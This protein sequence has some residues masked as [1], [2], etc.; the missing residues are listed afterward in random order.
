M[1]R[2]NYA[3]PNYQLFVGAFNVTAYV[4]SISLSVQPSE[5]STPL[6]WSGDFQ[7]SYNRK[8]LLNSLAE[9]AFD[10]IAEPNRWRP[11]QVPVSLVINGHQFPKLRID[12]YT[13]DPQLRQGRGTLIQILALADIDRPAIDPEIEAGAATPLVDV[14]DRLLLEAYSGASIAPPARSITGITGTLDSKLSTRNPIAD[15]Q[16]LCATSWQWLAVNS[17]EQIITVS[18]DPSDR[19]LLFSRGLGQVEWSPD[20]DAI[21][22]AAE[23]VIVTGSHQVIDRSSDCRDA[24]PNPNLD[25]Q[26]REREFITKTEQPRNLL[27]SHVQ[28]AKNDTNLVVAERKTVR[29]GYG[30]LS[31][32][33]IIGP[34]AT[35]IPLLVGNQLATA[36]DVPGSFDL[37]PEDGTEVLQTLTVKEQPAGV[38]FNDLGADT[39]LIVA[40]LTVETDVIK[41]TWK[42]RGVINPATKLIRTYL[43]IEKL[44]RLTTQRIP[45]DSNHSGEIDPKTGK[46]RCLEKPPAAEPR[47]PAAEIRLKT[48]VLRGECKVRPAGWTP[49]LKRPLIEDFGFLPSQAHADRLACQIAFRE[50]RRRDTV[51]I[52]MPLPSEWIAAGF[53]HLFR[54]HIHNAEFHADGPIISI[55]DGKAEFSFAGARIGTIPPVVDPP[56]PAPFI[57]GASLQLLL[58]SQ[59]AIGAAGVPFQSEQFIARGQTLV[60]TALSPLP[61]GLVLSSQGI[62]SGTP[63]APFSGVVSIQVTDG[64][65]IVTGTRQINI[66]P[67]PSPIPSVIQVI[68]IE[69]L[70]RPSLASLGQSIEVIQMISKP[71]GAIVPANAPIALVDLSTPF[72]VPA[73]EVV[74]DL[75]TPFIK[76]YSIGGFSPTIA[77]P[78]GTSGLSQIV[79]FAADDAFQSIPDIGFDITIYGGN[80]RSTLFVGSNSYLTMTAGSSAYNSISDTNPGMG[81]FVGGA[82]RSWRSVWVGSDQPGSFRIRWEGSGSSSTSGPADSL[83]EITL[84]DNG[85]IMLV[86]GAMAFTGGYNSLTDGLGGNTTAYTLTADSSW[87]F[88]PQGAGFTVQQGSYN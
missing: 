9:S 13:Y 14:I 56:L 76:R 44:E 72:I 70:S 3:T 40:E 45:L 65:S 12:R 6:L 62:L 5:P 69:E 84:F 75:S 52:K 19:P 24:T 39:S 54:C 15:A 66:G 79:S 2:I 41:A 55:A 68:E 80:R 47:Q 83:W 78:L 4:D 34:W 49:L 38:V 74:S 50:A 43:E 82:D 37:P 58:P 87:V 53:P 64:S 42:P 1:P 36:F 18:G 71:S 8:A 7:V 61:S 25:Q 16:K 81:L 27:F 85:V 22:F 23:Q 20:L 51:Q 59:A 30:T 31:A 77:T 60:F 86:T 21:N 17:A 28:A 33:S 26:G 35:P 67:P 32:V 10:P 73:I 63:A 11:A 29:K 46:P 48:E 88:E 57:P